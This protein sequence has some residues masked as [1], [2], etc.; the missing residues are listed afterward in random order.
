MLSPISDTDE[1]LNEIRQVQTSIQELSR[2]TLNTLSMLSID[3]RSLASIIESMQDQIAVVDNKVSDLS[4]CGE[5]PVTA[6]PT[7]PVITATPQSG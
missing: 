6:V 2:T 5:V 7:S 1:L 4:R 3:V